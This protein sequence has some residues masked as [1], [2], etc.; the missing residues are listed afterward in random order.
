MVRQLNRGSRWE[1]FSLDPTLLVHL[2]DTF[3]SLFAGG[4]MR[5]HWQRKGLQV[6]RPFNV[7]VVNH[8]DKK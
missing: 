2:P 4:D 5:R 8:V 7:Q 1:L 3:R 6:P